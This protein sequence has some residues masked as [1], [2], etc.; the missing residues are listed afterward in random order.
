M[1]SPFI[2]SF[3]VSSPRGNRVI[4]GRQEFHKGLDLVAINDYTVYAIADGV[5][6][7]TPYEANGFGY[8]IRQKIADGRVIYYGHLA[9][10]T[11]CV[12]AGQAVKAGDKLGIMGTTGSSTGLHTHIEIRQANSSNTNIDIAAFTGIPNER[13]TYYFAGFEQ[14]PEKNETEEVNEEVTQEQFNEMMNVYITEMAQ[15]SP[16]TWSKEAR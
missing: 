6:E 11:T 9:A 12:N 1:V 16:S 4:F 13:G 3:R 15:K 14:E 8:Y 7:A 10:G 2:G 5:I